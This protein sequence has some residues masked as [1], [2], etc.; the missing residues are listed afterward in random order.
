MSSRNIERH[1]S[2]KTSARLMLITWLIIGLAIGIFGYLITNWTLDGPNS[3]I[4]QSLSESSGKR[5]NHSISKDDSSVFDWIFD[6]EVSQ[7]GL[8][9]MLESIS[10]L[11]KVQLVDL[12]TKSS[13]QPWTPRLYT[14]QEVL[15]EILVQHSPEDALSSIEQFPSRRRVAL[16]RQVFTHWSI[17]NL[18][19]SLEAANQLPRSEMQIALNAIFEEQS[20]LS[21]Q[22]LYN[23]TNKFDF[24]SDFLSWEQEIAIY[25]MLEQEPSRAFDLLVS[26]GID[27]IEQIDLYRQIVEKWFQLDGLN[28]ITLLY[29]APTNGGVA[30]ELFHLVAEQDR[31]AALDVI[32]AVEED[33]RNVMGHRLL[34]RW[35]KDHP[36]DAFQAVMNLP[37]SWFR[38][39]LLRKLAF[40]WGWEDPSSVIDRL[41]EFPRLYR[42]SAVTAIASEITGENP[43]AALDR[44]E[45][46]RSIPGAYVDR[47]VETIIRTWSTDSPNLALDWVQS[48]VKDDSSKRIE[49]LRYVLPEYALVD[50]ERA[51][52]IAVEEFR[53]D[54]TFLSLQS[55]VI[56]SLL[57]AGRFDEA[58]KLLDLVRDEVKLSEQVSVGA[59]LLE[60]NRLDD[61]LSLT[62]SISDEEELEYFNRVARFA[63]ITSPSSNVLEMISR[64]PT[65]E[66]QS[67][68]ARNLLDRGSAE[69]FFTSEQLKTLRSFI[70]E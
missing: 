7:P 22:A 21:N 11:D 9:Q 44:I 23:A 6:E 33:R 25:E 57:S 47:A 51:M 14:I 61:V 60:H 34:D 29:D 67:E 15:V 1:D 20:E 53:F 52:N 42:S 24:E 66:F 43:K 70:S 27:D 5:S 65:A 26:D 36:E 48:N 41:L 50:S 59:E 37:K 63:V 56:S 13:T 12:T 69:R 55:H 39:S 32:L 10:S 4:D 58:I 16:L 38:H 3:R 40:D 19:E 62:E 49:L 35:V 2:S 68:V 30:G 45:E 31:V 64:L 54:N 17:L 46:L 18:E 8:Q 28:I